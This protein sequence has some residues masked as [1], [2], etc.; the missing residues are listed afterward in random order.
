MVMVKSKRTSLLRNPLVVSLLNLKWKLYGR[1]FYYISLIHLIITLLL[2]NSYMLTVPPPF[3]ING[4]AS[5]A[6]GC[7]IVVETLQDIWGSSCPRMYQS[8][9]NP[10][11]VLI[12]MF[13]GF[14]LIKEL[15]Q[16]FSAGIYYFKSLTNTIELPLYTFCVL[17]VVD[18]NTETYQRTDWQWQVGAIAILFSWAALILNIQNLPRFGLYVVMFSDVLRSFLSFLLVFFLFIFGFGFTFHV[19]LQNQYAFSRWWGSLIKTFI[20]MIG[21]FEYSD[22]FISEYTDDTFVAKVNYDAVTNIIF[23]VFVIV[24]SIV[25]MNLLI[26]LAVDD[27]K[28]VQDNAELTSLA[29]QVKLTLDVEYTLPEWLRR[30]LMRRYRKYRPNKYKKAAP[31]IRWFKKENYL[32]HNSLSEALQSEKS[33]LENVE[34]KVEAVQNK[35]KEVKISLNKFRVE[36]KNLTLITKAIAK[37]LEVDI[38]D[39]HETNDQ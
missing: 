18:F 27:I 8:W 17:V 38:T 19:L 24:M 34:S 29:M 35:L 33:D 39:H 2:I 4:T 11:Q 30:K 15:Y 37:H 9:Q 7:I 5:S 14:G 1:Y 21:E 32:D 36:T 12:F 3:G 6:A 31:I 23:V 22:M 13:A 28:E 26:G 25:I 20:M 16:L 10:A